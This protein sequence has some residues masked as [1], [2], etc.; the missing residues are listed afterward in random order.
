MARVTSLIGNFSGKMAGMVFANNKG[1]AYVRQFKMPT[2]PK[3]TAQNRVRAAFANGTNFWKGLTS[4]QQAA[5]NNFALHMYKPRKPKLGVTYSGFNAVCALL[6]AA[7]TGQGLARATT[8]KIGSAAITFTAGSYA[9]QSHAPSYSLSSQISTAASLPINLTFASAVFTAAGILTVHLTADQTMSTC[10][11]IVNPGASETCGF[12]FF[13]SNGFSNS[14]QFVQNPALHCIGATPP[15]SGL[16]GTPA[17][18]LTDLN[19]NFAT[20]D[21]NVSARKLWVVAG[22]LVRISC[23]IMSGS[24]QAAYIGEVQTTIT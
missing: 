23:Y 16:T 24:G 17:G 13:M 21:L 11:L 18:T 6:T 19:I 2:N 10:P 14:N 8:I 15:M 4:A 5:Y 1:G 20:A 12:V 9:G 7:A 22:N 3:S